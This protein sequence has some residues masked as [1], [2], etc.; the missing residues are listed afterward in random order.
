V[1]SEGYVGRFGGHLGAVLGSLGLSWW[2]LK[3]MLGGLK[4]CWGYVG[5]LGAFLAASEGYV[6][7]FGSY[8]G[9]MLGTLGLS[10]RLLTPMLVRFEAVLGLCWAA[11][12]STGGF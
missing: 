1:A 10:W 5:Q 6:G 2:P 8:I 9:T 3:A 7:P 12:G 11:W 4:P